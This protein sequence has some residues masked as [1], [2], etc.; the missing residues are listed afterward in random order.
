MLRRR[1]CNHTGHAVK[2]LLK[3]LTQTPARAIPRKHIE[4]VNVNSTRTVSFSSFRR[5]YFIKPIICHNL[6]RS[7][8]DHSPERIVLVGICVHTPIGAINIFFKS[9]NW[10]NK[11]S[12]TLNFTTH[13][14]L[15]VLNICAHN[16]YPS[17]FTRF[18]IQ[19]FLPC[20][21]TAFRTKCA[22]HQYRGK[23]NK[24]IPTSRGVLP[25]ISLYIVLLVQ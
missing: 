23:I 8:E 9:R 11:V 22:E 14:C 3:Q 6:A 5:K 2:S 20:S 21:F 7:I 10:I 15:K 1:R 25:R 19:R 24:V 17:H 4:I 18:S 13:L 16:R 12:C